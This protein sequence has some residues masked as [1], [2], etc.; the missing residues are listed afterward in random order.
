MGEKYYFP[1]FVV[2]ALTAAAAE[3]LLCIIRSDSTV[4]SKDGSSHSGPT[5]KNQFKWENGSRVGCEYEKFENIGLFKPFYKIF[6]LRDL[7][8]YAVFII[9]VV[10]LPSSGPSYPS[11][12]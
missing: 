1:P 8:L 2:P 5:K 7:P 6:F 4:I 10:F 11:S 3:C 12:F 9:I